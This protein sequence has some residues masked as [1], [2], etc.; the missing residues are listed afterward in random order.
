MR[1]TSIGFEFVPVVTLTM[2]LAETVMPVASA[3]TITA[4]L[5]EISVSGDE[6]AAARKG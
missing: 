1:P 4:G 2:P 5:N 3:G 6:R